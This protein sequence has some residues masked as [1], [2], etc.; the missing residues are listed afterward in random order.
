MVASESDGGNGPGKDL[1]PR[2]RAGERRDAWRFSLD[3][4]PWHGVM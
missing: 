3:R 4:A 2:R 1:G